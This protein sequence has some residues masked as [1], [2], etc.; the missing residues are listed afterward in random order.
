MPHKGDE[1]DALAKLDETTQR[2]LAER[3]MAGENVSAKKIEKETMPDIPNFLRVT[4]R[5]EVNDAMGGKQTHAPQ[6]MA[7]LFKH[8]VRLFQFFP[9][10]AGRA[11]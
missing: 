10:S 6:Q 2:E 9:K 3:A 5:Q 4:P 7:W 1:L 11:T 8:S